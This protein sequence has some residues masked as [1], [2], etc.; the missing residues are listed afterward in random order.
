MYSHCVEVKTMSIT[1]KVWWDSDPLWQTSGC[2]AWGAA[3]AIVCLCLPQFMG[4]YMCVTKFYLPAVQI[5][6]SWLSYVEF[7]AKVNMGKGRPWPLWGPVIFPSHDRILLLPIF[8]A[9]QDCLCDKVN[10]TKRWGGWQS[11]SIH[12][13]N[14]NTSQSTF[15]AAGFACSSHLFLLAPLYQGL[16]KHWGIYLW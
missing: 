4:I 16:T 9:H 13:H 12:S 1:I 11:L 8:L 6:G 10:G 7:N 3:P 15:R 14:K 2:F 5:K